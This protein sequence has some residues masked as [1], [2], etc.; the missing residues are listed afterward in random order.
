MS[1]RLKVLWK[2]S[3]E[4]DWISRRAAELHGLLGTVK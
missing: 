1:F 4:I 2:A 3:V